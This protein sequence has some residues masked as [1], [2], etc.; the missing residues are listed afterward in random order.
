MPMGRVWRHLSHYDAQL[1]RVRQKYTMCFLMARV[2]TE[3]CI[4]KISN[5][6][7]LLVLAAHRARQLSEGDAPRVEE[8]QDKPTVLALREIAAGKVESDDL[9]ENLV[10]NLRH[11]SPQDHDGDEEVHLVGDPSAMMETKEEGSAA[12]KD[13]QSRV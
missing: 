9:R 5:R 3:D 13:A 6:Y 12:Q 11:I 1:L 8:A 7:E 4:D 10:N 2:T